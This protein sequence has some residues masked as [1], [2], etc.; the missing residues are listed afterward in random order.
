VW[1]QAAADVNNDSV[2]VQVVTTSNN[3]IPQGALLLSKTGAANQTVL[4]YS[5]AVGSVPPTAKITSA[6]SFFRSTPARHV[7]KLFDVTV[8]GANTTSK[9]CLPA[10]QAAVDAAAK[11]GGGAVVYIPP[12]RYYVNGTLRLSG[13]GYTLQGAGMTSTTLMASPPP[14]PPPPP[15]SAWACKAKQCVP[16]K[17]GQYK[18]PKCSGDCGKSGDDEH[19]LLTAAAQ[20]DLDSVVVVLESSADVAPPP[21]PPPPPPPQ[22]PLIEIC[23]AKVCAHFTH[24]IARTSPVRMHAFMHS[25]TH[26]PCTLGHAPCYS[27]S[28]H[29]FIRSPIYH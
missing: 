6:T 10:I 5:L 3:I 7:G 19:S 17:N 28:P 2:P 21:A 1:E 9:D 14:P 18:N 24:R 29:A 8:Y 27:C 12:G 11:A 20:Y 15:P 22:P 25:P 13:G 26:A 16:Q 23:E 4:N